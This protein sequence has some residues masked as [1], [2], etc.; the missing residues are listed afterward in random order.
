MYPKELKARTQQRL[1]LVSVTVVDYH[2]SR[3]R[4]DLSPSTDELTDEM[5]AYT[6]SSDC[7]KKE[8]N[9]EHATV[10]VKLEDTML[11]GTGRPK[12]PKPTL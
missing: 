7:D 5:C 2:H 12:R 6:T 1:A 9:A 10:W 3:H 8:G 4:S 11:S